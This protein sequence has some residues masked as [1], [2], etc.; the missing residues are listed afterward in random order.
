M[1]ASP[2]RAFENLVHAQQ[3]FRQEISAFTNNQVAFRPGAN[4]W[5]ALQIVDHLIEIEKIVLATSRQT[6]RSAT[7]ADRLSGVDYIRY[8]IAQLLLSTSRRFKTPDGVPEPQVRKNLE[9][10]LADWNK[11]RDRWKE[12]VTEIGPEKNK[13]LAFRH[14]T[15]GP[16]TLSMAIN[17]LAAHIHHHL[18]QLH[19]LK[20]HP[21]LPAK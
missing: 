8:G 19:R 5:C 4:Q 10:Y 18:H 21:D 14:P 7:S 3:R 2:I 11:V 16:M 12:Y 15:A 6:L 17:F 9:G 20:K 13:L 1:C